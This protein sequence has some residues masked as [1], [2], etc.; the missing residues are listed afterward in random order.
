MESKNVI[1]IT[2]PPCNG[3]DE[4][5][6]EAL[7]KLNKI[8]SVG[9]YHVFKYMQKV[10]HIHGV[11]NL[12]RDNVFSISRAQL[13]RIRDSAFV[14]VRNEIIESENEID[15]VSTP[16]V[17]RIRPWG[18]YL[19]GRVDGLKIHHLDQLN[20]KCAIVFI[21]DLLRVRENMKND[22]LWGR[23]KV[24]LRNLAEWR[25]MVIQ[26]ID[27][28]FEEKS[29]EFEWIIFAKEHPIDTFINLILNEKPKLYI[30][31]HITGQEDFKDVKR[32]MD[33]LSTHFICID[34][35]TIKDWD[36]V[37]KYDET[38][39]T[40]NGSKIPDTIDI[41]INYS[42]GPETF[43]NITLEEIEDA[44]DLI[45]TQIVER[46]LQL[47]AC[48]HATVV[49]HK[50]E[51]PSY[52]VM[53]EVIHSTTRVSRPTYVLYPFKKRLSPFFEHY[54]EKK[55]NMIHGTAKIEELEDELKRK[56]IEDYNSWPTWIP[57]KKTI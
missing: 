45:R 1:L 48:V 39:Q 50:S 40:I 34:P 14:Q 15:I 3:R 19:S 33:K 18:D 25:S 49:Y 32:F 10:A 57:R 4:Y 27:E 24:N 53:N 22:P 29:Q 56:L 20:P 43:K 42:E 44:M 28:Y 41:T 7:P 23:M 38:I 26:I 36:V 46:D 11:H 5:I 12:T 30:S 55:E 54:I 31:F 47:I 8:L 16:A 35:Y 21:D 37:T 9:Y 17:F 2:G 6:R 13:E 51:T 52:G